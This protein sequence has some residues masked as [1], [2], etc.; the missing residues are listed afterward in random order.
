MSCN[1]LLPSR[2]RVEAEALR[3]AAEG[4]KRTG[5]AHDTLPG[6]FGWAEQGRHDVGISVANTA[7]IGENWSGRW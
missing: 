6:V 5:F 7:M 1:G 3:M 2:G 4:A